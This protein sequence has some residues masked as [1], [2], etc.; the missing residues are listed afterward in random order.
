MAD[1]SVFSNAL[2]WQINGEMANDNF[3]FAERCVDWLTES[4][5]GKRRGVL[6]IVDGEVIDNF[7]TD[8]LELPPPPLPRIEDVVHAVNQGIY[9]IESEN[10]FNEWIDALA[11]RI[12][13]RI[14]FVLVT[15]AL[16]A[17]ALIRLGQGKYY[18]EAGVPTLS[19]GLAQLVPSV[20]LVTQRKRWA[21]R[22][23]NFGEVAQ[24]LA[25]QF[26]EPL[27]VASTGALPS[28]RVRANPW[29]ARRIKGRVRKLWRLAHGTRPEIVSRRSLAKLRMRIAAL[30]NAVAD[31]TV[32]ITDSA[33][34][35][36]QTGKMV[37][38]VA[39]SQ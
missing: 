25:R 10:H 32:V 3:K 21:L 39:S 33:S 1:Q 7:Y 12:P 34:L 31:G 26:F 27:A 11:R 22:E 38:S 8:F 19:D 13:M 35:T 4:E 14:V 16:M 18:A 37:E 36:Q 17:L 23:G 9:G 28:V 20:S 6:F 24:A 30:R 2:L 5:S 15:I 29:K